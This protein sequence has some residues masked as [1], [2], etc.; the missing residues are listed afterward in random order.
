MSTGE[1]IRLLREQLKLSQEGFAEMIHV[2]RQTISKWENNIC[3]PNIQNLL[4]MC[5]IANVPLNDFFQE[6]IS[7]CVQENCML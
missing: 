4:S 6:E 7:T 1:K 5:K 2:S 3:L